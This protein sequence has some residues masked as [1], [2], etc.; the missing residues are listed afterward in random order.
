MASDNT[1]NIN[2]AIHDRLMSF[3]DSNGK[4]LST[5]VTNADGSDRVYVSLAPDE[6]AYPYLV[7][8]GENAQ[9]DPEYGNLRQFFDVVARCVHRAR[10]SEPDCETIA[11]IVE[12]ALLTW[13]ESTAT[14][15]VTQ[16]QFLIRRDTVPPSTAP[17][18]RDLTEIYVVVR[19]FSW[20]KFLTGAL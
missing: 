1:G 10:A 14:L 4:Q 16:G 12:T 7:V 8:H 19:C 13:R 3:V 9:G 17:G 6:I 2:R 15:G 18:D 11:D 5:Y 20:A